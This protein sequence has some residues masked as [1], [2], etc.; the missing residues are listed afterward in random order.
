MLPNK[1][2][3]Y[4]LLYQHKLSKKP[5]TCPDKGLLRKK[6]LVLIK[7]TC[8]DGARIERAAR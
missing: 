4:L 5:Q 8:D 7:L 3:Q 2:R 1:L 6:N